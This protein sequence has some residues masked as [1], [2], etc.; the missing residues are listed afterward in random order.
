MGGSETDGGLFE[1]DQLSDSSDDGGDTDPPDESD[2]PDPPDDGAGSPMSGRSGPSAEGGSADPATTS[3]E[4]ITRT[5]A[6]DDDGSESSSGSDADDPPDPP[7]DGGNGDSAFY[8]IDPVEESQQAFRFAE[9]R[10]RAAAETAYKHAAGSWFGRQIKRYTSPQVR[11]RLDEVFSRRMLGSVLVG[12]A[13]SKIVETSI[14]VA[15]G[16]SSLWYPV[17]WA[18]VFSLSTV[19]FVWWEH[20]SRRASEAAEKASETAEKATE[21]AS[22]AAEKATETASE[23]A[24]KATEAA[25]EATGEA[26]P[27]AAKGG[28][29]KRPEEPSATASAGARRPTAVHSRRRS[30]ERRPN[31][32]FAGES[33]ERLVELTDKEQEPVYEGGGF[34]NAGDAPTEGSER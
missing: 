8:E 30:A 17:M 23:A 34:K 28:T 27:P 32:R 29:A 26:T 24:E 13:F 22:E 9:K 5:D 15:F 4:P 10:S 20:L 7:D 18:A 25:A 31:K 6:S 14:G 1:F 16:D 12:G 2:R 11:K 21:T 19:V 3:N 33:G